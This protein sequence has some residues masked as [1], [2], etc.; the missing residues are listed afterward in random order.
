MVGVA[1]YD[2]M[3]YFPSA[4]WEVPA[5]LEAINIREGCQI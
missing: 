5:A 4:L 1:S 3:C 2:V